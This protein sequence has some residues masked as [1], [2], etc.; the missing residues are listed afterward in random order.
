MH[1][2]VW[3]RQYNQWS[4][5][6]TSE[7][8]LHIF[9]RFSS[10]LGKW[11]LAKTFLWHIQT[12]M[13][14]V[15]WFTCFS[16]FIVAWVWWFFEIFFVGGPNGEGPHRKHYKKHGAGCFPQHSYTS[17]RSK[18]LFSSLRV[19][20]GSSNHGQTRSTVHPSTGIHH[21][22]DCNLP[23]RWFR[24]KVFPNADG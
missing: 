4:A 10:Q 18:W 23:N 11:L 7:P 6:R 21:L 19:L 13:L 12:P 5:T 2:Q 9:H 20:P 17:L 8:S 1:S 15:R 24:L 16:L 22:V 14:F 3:S